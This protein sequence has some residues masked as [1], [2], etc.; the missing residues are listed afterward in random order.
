MVSLSV[1]GVTEGLRPVNLR[2]DLAPLADLIELAFSD[3]MDSSG[4]AAI[5]E[6]RTLSRVA[7]GL[8]ALLNV[9]EVAQGIGLGFVWIQDGKLVGNTS[10]YPAHLPRA[11]GSAWIIANVAVH[12]TYRGRGIARQLMLASMDMIRK[13]STS[14]LT[15]L[16]VEESNALARR[17][18]EN[19]GFKAERTFHVWRRSST[20]RIP[21]PQSTVYI[22]HRRPDEWKAEYELAAR[23]RPNAHG[24]MGWLRPTLPDLFRPSL[25]KML[26]DVV[27]MRSLERLIVRSPHDD[28]LRA[29]LWIESGFAA[30]ATQITLLV[31]PDYAGV[32]DDALMNLVTR[33]FGLRS[34]L[35]IEHPADDLLT[36]AVLQKYAFTRQRSLVHMTWRT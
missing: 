21:A 31:D 23:L 12:P 18:Y 26:V 30:S 17:L 9:N 36:T 22:T 33:R 7:P 11:F 29:S 15:L 19:L 14:S 35:T 25:L 3:S 13:R 27:N 8:G 5:R 24:G 4:R 2:T 1:S 32:Y 16:Q 10:V 20:A 28:R 6:M 34:A